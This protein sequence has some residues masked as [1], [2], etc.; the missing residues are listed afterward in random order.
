MINPLKQEFFK[1]LFNFLYGIGYFGEFTMV[2][3]VICT[4]YKNPICLFVYI[5]GALFNSFI[6]PIFKKWIHQKRP[7]NPTP[8]LYSNKVNLNKRSKKGGN[9]GMPSGHSENVFYSTIF[10][11]LNL[12]KINIVVILS[13]FI[14][15]ITVYQR[16]YF[17]N[18]SVPQ[19]VAGAFIGCIFGYLFYQIYFMIKKY[20]ENQNDV[21]SKSRENQ[22]D[23][24]SKSRENQNDVTSKSRE[25]H[26]DL[27]I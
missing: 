26:S 23:V 25:N 18:H 17:H 21:T 16:W 11:Y 4:L 10:L 7:N 2:L 8:F 20:F 15:C 13:F 14:C 3:I 22:N 27:N 6:N 9:Y 12:Q 1:Q 19:L 24:T 5:L